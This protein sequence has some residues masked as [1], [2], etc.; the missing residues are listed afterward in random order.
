MAFIGAAALVTC[1]VN[2]PRWRWSHVQLRLG[3]Q[4]FLHHATHERERRRARRLR[5]R[6]TLLVIGDIASFP[7]PTR[8]DFPREFD[9]AP[10][11]C[12]RKTRS[13]FHMSE[14]LLPLAERCIIIDLN[15]MAIPKLI[16]KYE[17]RVIL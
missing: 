15:F 11:T 14:V 16:Y 7:R 9:A 2:S 10:A 12:V 17:E 8:T 6:L 13:R 4:T 3:E 1:Q 5:A